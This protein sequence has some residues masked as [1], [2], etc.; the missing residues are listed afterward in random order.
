MCNTVPLVIFVNI[1]SERYFEFQFRLQEHVDGVRYAPIGPMS[2]KTI[3]II[4][5][6]FCMA[7]KNMHKHSNLKDRRWFLASKCTLLKIQEIVY[8]LTMISLSVLLIGVC[9]L[10]VNVVA[11]NKTKQKLKI[12]HPCMSSLLFDYPEFLSGTTRSK[13]WL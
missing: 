7:R 8:N 13:H 10:Y 12:N 4:V 5:L 11:T 1:Q 3:C 6:S 9:L 2:I